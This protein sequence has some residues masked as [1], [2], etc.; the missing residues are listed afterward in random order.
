M[1]FLCGVIWIV[2][3]KIT[4]EDVIIAPDII[5]QTFTSFKQGWKCHCRNEQNILSIFVF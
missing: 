3:E 2:K 5:C 4:Y 1:A